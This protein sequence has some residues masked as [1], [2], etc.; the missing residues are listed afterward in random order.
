MSRAAAYPDGQVGR[1]HSSKF[2]Q[3]YFYRT[4][5]RSDVTICYGHTYLGDRTNRWQ[6][7]KDHA[8]ELAYRA[9]EN[10]KSFG[11][12]ERAQL[13]GLLHD[14]GK[15]GDLFQAR[16]LGLQRGLD[17]RS[18]GACCAKQAFRDVSLTLA[19]QG[20]HIGLQPGDADYTAGI[21]SREPRAK[22]PSRVAPDRDGARPNQS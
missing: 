12:G 16:L 17:H 10:V 13:A 15:Y 1:H 2:G 11:E 7:M 20:H 22:A 18:A 8:S 21:D 6:L 5:E 9:E 19:I 14:L 3:N 4:G